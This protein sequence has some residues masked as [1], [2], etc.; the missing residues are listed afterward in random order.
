LIR[1]LVND[2]QYRF[3]FMTW[4]ITETG[5]YD[6]ITTQSIIITQYYVD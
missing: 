6:M 3:T 1:C 2:N 4:F 5:L